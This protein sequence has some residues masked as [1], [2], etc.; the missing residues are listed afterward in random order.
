MINKQEKVHWWVQGLTAYYSRDDEQISH[1][2]QNVE[3]QEQT[4]R[5][6]HFFGFCV[7]PRRIPW[8]HLVWTGA[9]LTY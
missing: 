1:N 5:N 8:F 3:E 9:E 2:R 7:R 6:F 4:K